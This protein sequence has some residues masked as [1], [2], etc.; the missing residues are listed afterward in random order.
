MQDMNRS[1]ISESEAIDIVRGEGRRLMVLG[2]AGLLVEGSDP[3]SEHDLQIR[4]QRLDAE[5]LVSVDDAHLLV[6]TPVEDL[7]ANHAA[8]HGAR[9]ALHVAS[10]LE[11]AATAF[12]GLLPQLARSRTAV[13]LQPGMPGDG[14]LMGARLPV[15]DLP[16][17][18]RGVL[19]HRGRTTR[20]QVVAPGPPDG[21]G[22]TTGGPACP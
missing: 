12:R 8:R 3:P 6:G 17:P 1:A 14:S 2:G 20:I 13:V 18:G 7:L 19:V 10:E 22:P 16:V 11:G 15:G 21:P 4:L 5:D 9:A